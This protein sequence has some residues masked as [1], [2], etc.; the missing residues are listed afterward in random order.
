MTEHRGIWAYSEDKNLAFEILGKGRE[1]ANQL[2]TDLTAILLGE[3]IEQGGEYINH[4]ADRVIVA[5]M[6]ALKDFFTE[7]YTDALYS[8]AKQYNPETI[9][10]GATKRG[11]ELAPRLA[12]RLEAGYTADCTNLEIDSDKRLVIKR[13]VLGG[14]AIATEAFN[15]KPQIVTVAAGAFKRPEPKEKK[16][17]VIEAKPETHAAR[18]KLLEKRM[19]EAS[20]VNIEAA[21]VVVGGGRGF[22][23]KEDF[24][25]LDDLASLLGGQVGYTRPLVED[26]KWFRDWIGLSG[27]K[28]RPTLYISVGISGVIQHVAGIRDSKLV[29]AI[30]KDADA[31]IH[32]CADYSLVGDLYE[33][34]PAVTAAVKKHMGK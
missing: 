8:L 2:G 33:L 5:D 24:K 28:I 32:E 22:D 13:V 17:E 34:V 4:G 7:T 19:L 23:K 31:P 30:N 29:V 18:K 6:P 16:G 1:L 25:L 11:K 10:M 27:H 12:T 26:R 21:D 15:T 9:L 3:N 20:N 14:N